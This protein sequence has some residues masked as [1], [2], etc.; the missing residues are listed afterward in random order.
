VPLPTPTAA[1]GTWQ[2]RTSVA[3]LGVTG[4][5]NAGD[6][7]MHFHTLTPGETI[8]GTL[9]EDF[10]A[11]PFIYLDGDVVP[12]DHDDLMIGWTPDDDYDLVGTVNNPNLSGTDTNSVTYAANGAFFNAPNNVGGVQATS[13]YPRAG[14]SLLDLLGF[15]GTRV[16]LAAAATY[17]ATFAVQGTYTAFGW[18]WRIPEVTACGDRPDAAPLILT[19]EELDAPWERYDPDDASAHPTPAIVLVS[20]NHGAIIGG[21]AVTITGSGFGLGATV[22]FDG[23][24][25]TDVEVVDERTI[26]CVTP[27]H[28]AGAAT[29]VITNMD[30]VTN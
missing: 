9:H 24:P 25:A 28:A 1:T 18:W 3:T 16:T 12:T 5:F 14:M 11:E 19:S 21:T 4:D 8:A 29:I 10:P 23:V 30:G 2:I 27:S 13:V 26:T 17:G 7:F 15:A 6:A 22:T 20:P